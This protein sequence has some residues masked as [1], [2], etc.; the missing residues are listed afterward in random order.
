M[1]KRFKL[2]FLNPFVLGWFLIPDD[3]NS[4]LETPVNL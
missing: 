1:R 3:L 4:V 2:E